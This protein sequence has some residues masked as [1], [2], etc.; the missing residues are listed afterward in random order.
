MCTPKP[1]HVQGLDMHVRIFM[2][3]LQ[4]SRAGLLQ[5]LACWGV[6]LVRPAHH[7]QLSCGWAAA[8]AIALPAV[9]VAL[10]QSSV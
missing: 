3:V 5:Q 2:C 4:L 10:A 8:H 1:L 9:D 7:T 6:E